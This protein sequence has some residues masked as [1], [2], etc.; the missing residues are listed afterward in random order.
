MDTV[1][2]NL[3]VWLTLGRGAVIPNLRGGVFRVLGLT[4]SNTPLPPAA[5]S[6][7]EG[8]H[9]PYW[10]LSWPLG[11]VR[12]VKMWQVDRV[13]R[14]SPRQHSAPRAQKSSLQKYMQKIGVKE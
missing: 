4:L 9:H 11:R 6:R 13:E 10:N 12:S 2:P 5:P 7:V 1:P 8:L 3:S 14:G